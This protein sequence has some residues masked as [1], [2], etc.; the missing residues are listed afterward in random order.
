MAIMSSHTVGL[1]VGWGVGDWSHV[2]ALK[3]M[4]RVISIQ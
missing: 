4:L 2:Q 1:A 3:P